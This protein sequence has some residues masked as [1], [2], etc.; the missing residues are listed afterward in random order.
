MSSDGETMLG[1][2]NTEWNASMGSGSAGKYF[3]DRGEGG[4]NSVKHVSFGDGPAL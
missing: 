3:D 1:R 4:T 2:V